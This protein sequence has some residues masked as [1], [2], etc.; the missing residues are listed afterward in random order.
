MTNITSILQYVPMARNGAF[1]QKFSLEATSEF[2][3]K[4][5]LLR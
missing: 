2:E 5:S 1:H 4:D 3:G